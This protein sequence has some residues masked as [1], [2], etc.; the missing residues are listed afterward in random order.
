M[1]AGE[2]PTVPRGP[3]TIRDDFGETCAPGSVPGTS[4][5]GGAVRHVTD[6][7]GRVSI[8]HEALRFSPLLRS[9]W[10]QI[11]RASCRERV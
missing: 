10:G 9:G 2:R 8:D 1:K 5:D 11:G 7:E 4:T 3:E 6:L